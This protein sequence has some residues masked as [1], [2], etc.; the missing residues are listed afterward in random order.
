MRTIALTLN[1]IVAVSIIAFAWIT[2][3]VVAAQEQF[4]NVAKD[5][6]Y[7]LQQNIYFEARNQSIN[8]HY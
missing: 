1:I 4:E 7:C 6:M 5:D 2:L 8:G 3:P